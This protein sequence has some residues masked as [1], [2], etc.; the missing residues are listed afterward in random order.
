MEAHERAI[1][2]KLASDAVARG[3]SVSVF[4]GEAWALKCGADVDAIVNAC[5]STDSDVL[6]FRDELGRV[7]GSVLIVYG[8][9]PGETIADSSDGFPFL[10]FL[11]GAEELQERQA[12]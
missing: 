7:V 11:E 8:N 5:A 12:A 9:S 3:W 2:R 1:I 10:E 6:R 4:D